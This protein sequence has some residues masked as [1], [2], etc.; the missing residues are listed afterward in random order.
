MHPELSS[1]TRGRDSREGPGA[2][3]PAP[4][5]VAPDLRLPVLSGVGGEL[6]HLREATTGSLVLLAFGS[7]TGTMPVEEAIDPLAWVDVNPAVRVVT[8]LNRRP[9]DECSGEAPVGLVG[10]PDAAAARRYGV[11]YTAGADRIEAAFLVNWWDRV[12]QSWR[13]PGLEE[14]ADINRSIHRVRSEEGSRAF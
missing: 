14:G 4:G 5:E 12:E 9:R 1:A 2:R 3:P 8:V 6:F 7:T 10:D 11:D 13:E